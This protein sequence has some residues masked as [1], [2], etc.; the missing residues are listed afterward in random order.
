MIEFI[1]VITILF[2]FRIIHVI[3]DVSIFELIKELFNDLISLLSKKTY[4]NHRKNQERFALMNKEEKEKSKKFAL[5]TSINEILLDLGWKSKNITVEAFNTFIL[6]V[7]ILIGIA[8]YLNI[9]N[10]L[11]T[12]LSSLITMILIYAVTFLLSRINHTRRK[13]AL[14]D[15]E[16][17]L[18]SN[19]SYGLKQ[20]IE[21]NVS[22]IDEI[23]RRPFEEFLISIDDRNI[24]IYKAIDN[25]NAACGEQFNDFCDKCKSYE[26]ERRPGME[27][28]FQYNISRNAFIRELD[29]KCAKSFD[30]MNKNF[31]YSIGVILMF[32][33]Y[34]ILSYTDM[35]EFYFSAVGKIVLILYF[36]ISS[37]TFIVLQYV[38][39]KPFRYG[40]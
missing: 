33:L 1:V 5:N 24:D 23:V 38:Q 15:A 11:L 3:T 32:V 9:S 16:D 10:L 34:N 13:I 28:N 30:K 35:R 19:M 39:S 17:Y 27:N 37:I 40:K 25:L 14:M 21:E 22:M 31:F 26:K 20:S 6:I 12:I 29:R 36:C 8:I 2:L 4:R 18:C 7:S